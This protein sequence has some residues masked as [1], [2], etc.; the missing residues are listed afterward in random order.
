MRAPLN[1]LPWR[2]AA[3]RARRRAV[4]VRLAVLGVVALLTGIAPAPGLLNDIQERRLRIDALHGVLA[5]RGHDTDALADLEQRLRIAAADLAVL[6]GFE[7]ERQASVQLLEA[8]ATSTPD[9][10]T[11]EALT[12][13]TTP[14]RLRLQGLGH[15]PAD[16]SAYAVRLERVAGLRQ[17]RLELVEQVDVAGQA[18]HR[19]MLALE[20][21]ASP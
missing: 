18:G 11:L 17:P 16:L 3:R 8:L 9:S 12:H 15:S 4:W 2:A 14:A 5:T 1:L 7:Q 13:H 19:F 6:T 21:E 20:L 10:I